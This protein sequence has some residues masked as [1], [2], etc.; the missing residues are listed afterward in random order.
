MLG[1]D[2]AEFVRSDDLGLGAVSEDP[3]RDFMQARDGNEEIEGTIGS[4][5]CALGFVPADLGDVL[6]DARAETDMDFVVGA[7]LGDQ[8]PG[9]S[10][11]SV[12]GKASGNFV[13][14]GKLL[15]LADASDVEGAHAAVERRAA[16]DVP[17]A[18]A[19]EE[20][21]GAQSRADAG[22]FGEAGVVDSDGVAGADRIEEL[23]EEGILPLHD[24]ARSGL[25]FDGA[26][27]AAQLFAQP[28]GEGAFELHH[29]AMGGGEEGESRAVAQFT[30]EEDQ[31]A[32]FLG[33]EVGGR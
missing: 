28:G 21:V 7:R 20:T 3:P 32:S 18:V 12:K 8:V 10:Q 1:N 26:D 17:A 33:G 2:L 30:A 19:E 31:R 27:D 22:V 15:E 24:V 6:G 14:V 4:E 29:G 11:V 13:G 25:D 16:D 23:S 9:I 5:A